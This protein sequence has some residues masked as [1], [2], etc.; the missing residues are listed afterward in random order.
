GAKRQRHPDR[1]EDRRLDE[2]VENDTPVR[3]GGKRRKKCRIADRE[4]KKGRDQDR[5]PGPLRSAKHPLRFS[6]GQRKALRRPRAP[7]DRI[8]LSKD[9]S[10]SASAL[11]SDSFW[12]RSR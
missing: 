7:R 10:F 11:R 1:E 3:S 4:E 6:H 12:T 5:P 2:M 9:G 8:L